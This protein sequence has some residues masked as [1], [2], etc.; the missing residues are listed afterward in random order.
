VV[1]SST[2]PLI[3]TS[4]IVPSENVPF[5]QLV[6]PQ[7]RLF[8]TYCSLICWISKTK[9]ANIVLCDNSGTAHTFSELGILAERYHKQLE[10]L[11]FRGDHEKIRSQGK[12]YGEG[13][14]MKYVM[15]HSHLLRDETAFYKVSGR[16]FVEGFDDVHN[17]HATRGIVFSLPAKM[18]RWKKALLSAAGKYRAVSS[19]VRLLGKGYVRTTFYKCTKQYYMDNLVNRFLYIDDRHGYFF[20]HALMGPLLE[21]GFDVFSM[22]PRLVGMSATN[23]ILYDGIDYSDEVKG[24]AAKLLC[25]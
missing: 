2:G 8:Q 22:R 16:I 19:G 6:D 20:E 17:A 1:D 12:G 21:S 18:G 5:L 23:G 10:V 3:V 11:T 24:L 14:I 15:E 7:S 4:A 13:E 25:R 9:I